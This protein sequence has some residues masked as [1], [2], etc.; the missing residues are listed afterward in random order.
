MST[1]RI[2]LWDLL[3]KELRYRCDC[4][5]LLKICDPCILEMCEDLEWPQH[6]MCGERIPESILQL[7]L[8]TNKYTRF[9]ARWDEKVLLQSSNIKR[10]VTPNC[11]GVYTMDKKCG[12]EPVEFNCPQCQQSHCTMC[13][14]V[15]TK[16]HP[17]KCDKIPKEVKD[18][19]YQNKILLPKLKKAKKKYRKTNKEWDRLDDLEDR[20]IG[21]K[22]VRGTKKRLKKIRRET[23]RVQKH[24]TKCRRKLEK[25]KSRIIK[26]C[27]TCHTLVQKKNGCNHMTCDVCK[28]EF[29]WKT[30]QVV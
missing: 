10:C 30:A 21:L 9:I 8:G 25:L 12:G 2:C 6:G 7:S 27:P 18:A 11:D 19:S 29:S 16:K 24:T 20:L 22:A 23:K 28:S 4:S 17:S 5:S 1:C 26:M 3:E 15:W 13:S 14:E